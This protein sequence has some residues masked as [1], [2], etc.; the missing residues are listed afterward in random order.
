MDLPAH[1]AVIDEFGYS[2]DLL[3]HAI[4]SQLKETG[5]RELNYTRIRTVSKLVYSTLD[6]YFQ[7]QF[8]GIPTARSINTSILKSRLV[9]VRT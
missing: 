6:R 9:Y 7:F 3:L 8:L 1:R 2:P 5:E 4:E